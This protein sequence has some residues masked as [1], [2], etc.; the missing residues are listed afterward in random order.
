MVDYDMLTQLAMGAGAVGGVAN[1][2]M[3]WVNAANQR[4]NQLRQK[5]LTERQQAL[6]AQRLELDGRAQTWSE[7]RDLIDAQSRQLQTN[8]FEMAQ[9]TGKYEEL[10]RRHESMEAEWRGRH[11]ESI[12]RIE[13]LERERDHWRAESALLRRQLDSAAH[14]RR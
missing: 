9:L 7:M 11:L 13:A 12:A 10:L 5:A 3:A 4:R 2:A 1:A 8:R 14:V 6:D